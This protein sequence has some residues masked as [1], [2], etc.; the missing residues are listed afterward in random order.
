MARHL[1]FWKLEWKRAYHRLPQ[2]FAGAAVLLFLAAS[3]AFLASRLLYGDAAAGRITVGVVRPEG[4]LLSEKAVS[5]AGSLDSVSSM[6]DFLYF[7]R[8]EAAKRLK[9]GELFAVMEIPDQMV[10]G[11]MDGT[12]PPVRVLLP[13]RAG[14][15]SKIFQELTEAGAEILGSAQ[16]GIYAGG[17]LCRIYGLETSVPQM[18]QELNRLFLRCSLPRED[19]FRYYQVSAAGDTDLLTFYGISAYVLFLMMA[20][21]PVSGYLLPW[22]K[23]MKQKLRMAGIRGGE[24][25]A[26]RA[27][28]LGGLYLAVTAALAAVLA[29]AGHWNINPLTLCKAAAEAVF[30]CLAAA[31]FVSLLYQLAGTIPGGIMLLFLTATAEHFLA[32]GFLPMVFLPASVQGIA[33]ALPSSVLMEGVRAIVTGSYEWAVFGKLCL[34]TAAGICLGAVLEGKEA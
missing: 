14:V 25:A 32:G 15:E 22:K 24:R 6:C 28:C 26:A 33:P 27:V 12:N 5:M 13:A 18:E 3:A 9:S 29:A 20:S 1:I 17:E 8:E 11:I 4:D 34:M 7:D 30:V 19:Y 16:A 21:I 31:S 23:V 10:E 2:M